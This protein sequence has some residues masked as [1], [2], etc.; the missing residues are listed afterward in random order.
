M[1][2]RAWRR[3]RYEISS[4]YGDAIEDAIGCASGSAGRWSLVVSIEYVSEY[5]DRSGAGR[6]LIAFRNRLSM[7][8]G[9]S[10]TRVL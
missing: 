2:Y 1:E 10:E 8:I 7:E 5:R 4:E 3:A 9:V 6:R